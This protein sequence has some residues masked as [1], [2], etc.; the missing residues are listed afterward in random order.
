MSGAEAG[1]GQDAAGRADGRL[2]VVGAGTM[3]SQIALQAAL[4]GVDVSL[5]DL[6]SAQLDRARE[7]ARELLDRRV[8][9]GRLTPAQAAD[10]TARMAFSGDLAAQGPGCRWAIEAVVEELAAK[11]D[12]FRALA[13]VL[14]ADAGIAT[15]SSHLRAAAVTEG[16]DCRDRSLNMHFF[17][18]V[19]VMDLVEVVASPACA[20]AYLDRAVAWARR[21]GRTPVVLRKDLDG[22][23]V[24]RVLG[25]ASREAFSLLAAGV[26]DMAD[27]DTAVRQGLRWPLGP[28]QLA[29]LSG[30]DVVYAARRH[31]YETYG[32]PADLHT[33]E[34]LEP[35]VRA[36]RLG[37]KSGAGFYDYTVRPPRP[38]PMPAA[39]AP[40]QGEQA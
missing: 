1:T 10:A 7:Q 38:L 4:H 28:F 21:I 9:K 37:R 19:L 12:V 26:A 3:G 32:D 31:R 18:P 14:P 11:R 33:A 17:H 22:F 39:D 36:G 25:G 8:A 5:V 24:N 30:L 20:P 34:I 35:L 13:E 40:P 6:S 29:D 23:L 16:M 27:I 15:N 2:L